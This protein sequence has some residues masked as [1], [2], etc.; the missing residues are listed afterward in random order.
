MNRSLVVGAALVA[1]WGCSKD[2]SGSPKSDGGAAGKGGSTAGGATGVGGSATGGQR[3][4]AGTGGAGLGGSGG[5]GTS[6]AAGSVDGGGASGAGGLRGGGGTQVDPG[7]ACGSGA[8]KTYCTTPGSS[9][10]VSTSGTTCLDQGAT[11]AGTRVFCTPQFACPSGEE[12]C[13][14]PGETTLVG[15]VK[16]VKTCTSPYGTL[17]STS[18]SCAAAQTCKP[19]PGLSDYTSCQ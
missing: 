11:C 6:G 15:S 14:L 12:C 1:A 9:C 8:A 19:L 18:A 10:C 7:V 4:S 5:G 2:P 13:A 16:C 17:C 3:N